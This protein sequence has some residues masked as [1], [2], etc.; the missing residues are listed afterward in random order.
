MA[1]TGVAYSGFSPYYGPPDLREYIEVKLT[2]SLLP[3]R[4]YCVTFYASSADSCRWATSRIGAYLSTD[5]VY[6]TNG[7]VLNYSPQVEN[8]YGNI[9]TDATNWTEI[10]GEFTALGGEKF[11]TIGNFY[12]D[13]NTDTVTIGNYF[14]YY[15]YYYIDD[16]SVIEMVYDTANAGGDKTICEGDSVL[17]GTAQCDGCTYQWLP[18][19]G[20]SDAMAAQPMASPAQTT[21]YVLTLTD[22]TTTDTC[23][24]RSV[25][26]TTDTLT[27][28]IDGCPPPPEQPVEVYNIFTPNH[29]GLNETFYINN[30]PAESRLIVF[31]RWGSKV[32]ENNNY[33]NNWDGGKVPDG[34]YFYILTLPS[35]ERIHGFVEIRR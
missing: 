7:F 9:I 17:L 26:I 35:K 25:S 28:Y 31:N 24:C 32:Y 14:L 16:V 34:T 19:T 22:T 11:L 1:R 18:A 27:V 29:D 8:P 6:S 20:L 4:K 3:N 21:T 5:S 33:N 2:D 15:A 30:L 12:N 23:T 10:S 13:A